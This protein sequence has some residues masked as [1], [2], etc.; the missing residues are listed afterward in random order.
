MQAGAVAQGQNKG[1]PE[2]ELRA[3]PPGATAST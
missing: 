3:V 2:S 1:K